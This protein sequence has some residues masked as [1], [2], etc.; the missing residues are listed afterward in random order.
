MP[1]QT[2]DVQK[3]HCD[4]SRLKK[5]FNY[6]PRITVKKGVYNFVQW[7]LSIIIKGLKLFIHFDFEN[8]I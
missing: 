4:N 2:G 6:K 1:L 8:N 7:F 5:M 3:T